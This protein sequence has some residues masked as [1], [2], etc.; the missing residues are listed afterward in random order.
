M[1]LYKIELQSIG[2]LDKN[3]A[4]LTYK[5][6]LEVRKAFSNAIR[7]GRQTEHLRGSAAID[8]LARTI[9]YCRERYREAVSYPFTVKVLKRVE[10]GHIIKRELYD[11]QTYREA[12][13]SIQEEIRQVRAARRDGRGY[14]LPNRINR[15]GNPYHNGEPNRV[16]NVVYYRRLQKEKKPKD[17][18]EYVGIELEC[19]TPRNVD[20]SK[21]APFHEYVN[22]GTDGSIDGY[23]EGETGREIRVC[24][25]RAKVR[26]IVPQITE[27]L[28]SIGARVNRSCGLHVHLDQRNAANVELNYQKLVRA[29]SLLYQV[30][31]LSRR[32]NRYCRRSRQYDFRAAADGNRYHAINANAYHRYRTL[33]VRLFGGTLSGSKIV[34]WIETLYGIVEGTPSLRCPKNFDIA[35]RYWKLSDENLVWLKSRAAQFA[36]LNTAPVAESEASEP[37]PLA[38]TVSPDE[39]EAR[40][41]RPRTARELQGTTVRWNNLRENQQEN[42]VLSADTVRR[43]ARQLREAAIQPIPVPPAPHVVYRDEVVFGNG[44]FGVQP[45]DGWT[46]SAPAN[47]S[48]P[49]VQAEVGSIFHQVYDNVL[50]DRARDVDNQILNALGQGEI[51][52]IEGVSFAESENR[53]AI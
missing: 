29:Q 51:G 43:A 47:T 3:T 20:L 9:R 52:T 16:L 44:A 27:A 5:Y 25:P 18:Q 19:I 42:V 46:V 8:E 6:F 31:P 38:V 28:H 4:K 53:E 10:R 26:E 50:E 32:E 1:S 23:R 13:E 33:E 15:N 14:C 22:V 36:E 40:R 39:R 37:A 24:I 45:I 12:I 2:R 49:E 17:N 48:A 35:K 21:L 30:V 7:V 11:G 34:N 41:S